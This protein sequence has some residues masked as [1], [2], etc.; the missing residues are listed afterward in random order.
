MKEAPKILMQAHTPNH[1][2]GRAR[3]V[4]AIMAMAFMA[5]AIAELAIGY[6]YLPG[7]RGSFI[8]LS[9]VP[10]IMV[11]LAATLLSVLAISA[12]IDHYDKRPNEA[13]YKSLQGRLGIVA[14]VSLVSAPFVEILRSFL[15]RTA[16][17]NFFSYH[18]FAADIPLNVHVYSGY[19][20]AID[21]A[22]HSGFAIAVIAGGLACGI[23]GHVIDRIWGHRTKK[24]TL[25]LYSLL[26][27]SLSGLGLLWTARQVVAGEASIG[28]SSYK[29]SILAAREPAKFNAVILTRGS[30]FVLM[31]SLGIGGLGVSMVRRPGGN[32]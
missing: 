27:V 28:R 13:R 10:T 29:Q 22:L 25:L 6:T 8:L 31:F 15:P 5:Y 2:P 26:L 23:A 21:N 24:L 32:P 14:I 19:I 4:L 7:K 18:G 30:V 11:A 20:R 1:I 16:A 12:V 9:G 3:I 17:T